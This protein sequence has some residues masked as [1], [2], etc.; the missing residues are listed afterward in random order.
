MWLDI[1][2]RSSQLLA[3]DPS[4]HVES[5]YQT[6]HARSATTALVSLRLIPRTERE[7]GFRHGPPLVVC[8]AFPMVWFA[9]RPQRVSA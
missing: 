3:R 9:V 1:T 7:A 4:T 8:S 2:G 5:R 6:A